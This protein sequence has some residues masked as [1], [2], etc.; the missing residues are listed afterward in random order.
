MFAVVI[1]QIFFT[2]FGKCT[3]KHFILFDAI[4][5][6]IVLLISIFDGLL[7]V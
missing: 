5:N 4:M 3:P 2:Y 1:I 6:G 7:L